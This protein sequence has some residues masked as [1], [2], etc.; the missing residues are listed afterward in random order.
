MKGQS[1]IEA[2][3]P[4]PPRLGGKYELIFFDHSTFAPESFPTRRATSACGINGWYGCAENEVKQLQLPRQ[5][6]GDSRW[7]VEKATAAKRFTGRVSA[8]SCSTPNGRD[9]RETLAT[10]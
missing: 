5:L 4:L 10:P 9:R 1:Q 3:L 2:S 7:P 8:Y 6:R